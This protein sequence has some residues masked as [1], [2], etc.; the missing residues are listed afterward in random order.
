MRSWYEGEAVWYVLSHYFIDARPH[1]LE[2]SSKT[3]CLVCDTTSLM[4]R[5]TFWNP[6][7]KCIVWSVI[8][9]VRPGLD[10]LV[11]RV[12]LRQSNYCERCCKHEVAADR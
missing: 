5:L 8:F 4:P 1:L 10:R 9:P 7:V 11:R 12:A 2:S 3:H 6:E